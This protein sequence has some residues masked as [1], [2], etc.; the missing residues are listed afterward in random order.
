MAREAGWSPQPSTTIQY[1]PWYILTTDQRYMVFTKIYGA[2][3]QMRWWYP[4]NCGLLF[5]CL[6][7]MYMLMPFMGCVGKLMASNGQYGTIKTHTISICWCSSYAIGEEVANSY[8]SIMHYDV[9]SLC[10][11]I[12][13]IC[14]DHKFCQSICRFEKC[15]NISDTILLV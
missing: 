4:D 15:I 11:L 12:K 5:Q 13:L 9:M 6:E 7:G 10:D 3:I 8:E 2:S 14:T 1:L